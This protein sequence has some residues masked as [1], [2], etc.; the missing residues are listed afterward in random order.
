MKFREVVGAVFLSALIVSALSAVVSAQSIP[1]Q[2]PWWVQSGNITQITPNKPIQITGPTPGGCLQLTSSNIATTTGAPCGSGSGGGVATSS[3]AATYPI[4]LST[5]PF[6]TYGI[7]FG[8]TTANTWSLLQTFTSGFL[9]LASSTV[10]A[11]LNIA[12]STTSLATITGNTWLTNLATPAGTVLAVD[13]NGKIIATTTPQGTVTSVT[14]VYPVQSTGG[15]TPAISLA[16]GTTTAN[17]WGP[18][19][20]FSNASTSLLTVSTNQWLTSLA[21]AAGAFLA[22]DNNGKIV[23]TTSPQSTLLGTTGQVAYF[24]GTNQAE[25]TSTV[26]I[27]AASKVGIGTTTP[28]YPLTVVGPLGIKNSNYGDTLTATISVFAGATGQIGGFFRAYGPNFV[29]PSLAGNTSF[30]PDGAS[31]IVVFSNANVTSGGSG[32]IS[33]RGGGYDT[34]AESLF[35]DATTTNFSHNNVGIATSAPGTL[36]SVQ[37]IANFTAATS[38]FQST[39]GINLTSGCFAVGGTCIS[40]GG[41]GTVGAGTAGQFPYYETNGTT[42]TATSTLF[43]TSAGRVGI[44]T[45]TPQTALSV[46]GT[47]GLLTL[48]DT[49]QTG[50]AALPAVIFRDAS[51]TRLGFVGDGSLAADIMQLVADTGIVK[52]NTLAAQPIEFFVNNA[53]KMRVD[54]TGNVGIGT[55]TP[56]T[57]FSVQG[58]ANFDTATSTFSSS[59]GIKLSGGCF[60]MPS[61][62]CLTSGGSGTVTNIATTFPILGGPITTTGTL[63]FGGLTTSTAAVVGNIPYF[64]SANAFANV[65]TTSLTVTSPITFSGT[66]GAQI[67]GVAG[68][69]ACATCNTFGWPWSI[70]TTFAT[71]TNATTTP[72]WFQGGLFASSTSATIPTLVVTQS[73][74]GLAAKFF[75]GNV[76]IDSG[77]LANITMGKDTGAASYNTIS[78]N[79]VSDFA[80]GAGLT[81]TSDAGEKQLYIHDPS[82][83][84]I[85]M[86]IGGTMK[87]TVT[88]TGLGV[89]QTTPAQ[90]LDVTGTIRQSGCTTIGT[91]S[92]NGSGDIVCT[93]S[94]KAFKDNIKSLGVTMSDFLKIRPVTFTFKP[95]MNMGTSSRAGFISEEAAAI[96]PELATYT[97]GGKPYGVDTNAILS[98]TVSAVQQTWTSLQS[99]VARVTG[100][101]ARVNAQDA[102]I[103]ELEKRLNALEKK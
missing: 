64:S 31:N 93:V 10:N 43:V 7:A 50:A 26:F 102:K 38:T 22:V 83:G 68:S 61:G 65:A 45:T 94:S 44:G 3:F 14:G 74:A 4:T 33:L 52:L 86:N 36:L 15:T 2:S 24:A 85:T 18:L 11:L 100:L 35:M 60:A 77:T 67:G 98:F 13:P 30:G 29:V 42:L 92:A 12:N 58:V 48:Q 101:E 55:T 28:N 1:S 70:A 99:L 76:N 51:Y 103:K 27:S 82:G 73:G 88:A 66:L 71:T 53:E 41:S 37:G 69:F 56:G 57:L 21:T 78:L 72:A 6:I 16:F 90:A 5:S 89:L 8:T 80:T 49:S 96:N 87:T 54:S 75:G 79:G 17:T 9:S 19:Q 25:G 46:A 39:G 97:K 20:T 34:P 40:S 23:A 84:R 81:S 47:A 95:I 62:A 63:T 32:G 59:G 91:L